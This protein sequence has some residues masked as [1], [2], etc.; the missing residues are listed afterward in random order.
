MKFKNELI[1]INADIL[2]NGAMTVGA[3]ATPPLLINVTDKTFVSVAPTSANGYKFTG[4]WGQLFCVYNT[5]GSYEAYIY[6]SSNVM[7]GIVPISSAKW[8]FITSTLDCRIL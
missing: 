8:L 3:G 4:E 5:S 1:E 7:V 6:N 2:M